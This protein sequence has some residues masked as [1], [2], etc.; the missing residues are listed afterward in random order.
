MSTTTERASRITRRTIPSHTTRISARQGLLACGV[1]Y[2]VLYPVVNDV[3]AATIYEGYSRLD[4]AVSELSATGAPT[5]TFLTF[6]SPVFAG[7][8]T[9]FGIGIWRSA[10]GRRA[11]RIAGA[12]VAAHGVVSLLWMIAPMSRREVIAAGGST[13]A[14]T[15]HLV[16]AAATGVFVAAYV[17]SAAFGF[18]KIFKLYSAATIVTSLVFGLMSA[19]VEQIEAGEPTPYM[20]LFERIGIGA[21]LLWMAAMAISLWRPTLNG[22]EVVRAVDARRT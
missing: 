8:L 15:M 14:D 4:Q 7:L 1:A 12:L 16:L 11:L 13:S 18:G 9:A 17:T 3:I 21:W 10:V 6:V 22:P 5:H 19:Q 20:G 2:A